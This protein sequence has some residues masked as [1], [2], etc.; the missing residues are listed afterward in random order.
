MVLSTWGRGYSHLSTSVHRGEEGLKNRQNLSTWFVNALLD[1]TLFDSV[2]CS[3]CQVSAACVCANLF[4]DRWPFHPTEDTERG[5]GHRMERQ[6]VEYKL[7]N[8]KRQRLQLSGDIDAAE[9]ERMLKEKASTPII[10]S[11]WTI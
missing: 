2:Y 6:C 9:K 3:P 11:D 4:T 5:L 1:L 10:L 8:A 7:P